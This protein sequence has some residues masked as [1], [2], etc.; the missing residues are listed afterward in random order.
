MTEVAVPAVGLQ[1]LKYY[2]HDHSQSFRLQLLGHLTESDL[3]ELD[4]CWQ[5]AKPS[6]AGRKIKLDLRGLTSTDAAGQQWLG[7]MAGNQDVEVLVSVESS[8]QWVSGAKVEVTQRGNVGSWR[9][10]LKVVLRAGRKPS[11]SQEPVEVA[12]QTVP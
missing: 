5:T 4:G 2:I 12:V 1:R 10:R 7:A 8:N 11:R 3:P 9:D 6:V